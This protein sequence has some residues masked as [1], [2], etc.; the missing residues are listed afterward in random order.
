MYYLPIPRHYLNLNIVHLEMSKCLAPF[1]LEKNVLVKCDKLAVVSVL[2]HSRIKDALLAA[3][4]R[5]VLL[6][7]AWYDIMI[8]YVHVKGK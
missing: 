7:A 3:C 5:N 1:G 2:T 8:S 6:M 4:A